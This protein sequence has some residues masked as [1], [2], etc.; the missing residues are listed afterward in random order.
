MPNGDTDKYL[1]VP[2]RLCLSEH[3]SGLCTATVCDQHLGVAMWYTGFRRSCG[4]AAAT[5]ANFVQKATDLEF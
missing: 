3:G 2:A 1:R 4:G 5:A